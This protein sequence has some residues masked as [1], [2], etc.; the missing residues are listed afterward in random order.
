[1]AWLGARLLQGGSRSSA[2]KLYA[3]A[4]GAAASIN[5]H[6]GGWLQRASKYIIFLHSALTGA[7]V[8][9]GK[10]LSRQSARLDRSAHPNG[11]LL[12]QPR[13]SQTIDPELISYRSV[14]GTFNSEDVI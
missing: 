12:A 1:V 2:T 13:L 5:K 9:E 4:G 6:D 11:F 14:T 10:S 3:L 8:M 7:Y